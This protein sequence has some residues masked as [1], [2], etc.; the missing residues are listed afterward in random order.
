MA[1]SRKHYSELASRIAQVGETLVPREY[2]GALHI[3][4][5][6]A[7]VLKADNPRFDINRFMDAA[8][9][10]STQYRVSMMGDVSPR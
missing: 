4:C 2:T 9:V 3:V 8:G 7:S 5:A 10:D 1:M 6:V